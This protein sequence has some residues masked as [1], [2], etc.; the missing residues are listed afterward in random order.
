MRFLN[1]VLVLLVEYVPSANMT[2]DYNRRSDAQRH[3]TNFNFPNSIYV[4]SAFG[5]CK[6]CVLNV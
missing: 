1:N 4:P 3:E 6:L 5:Y 2:D